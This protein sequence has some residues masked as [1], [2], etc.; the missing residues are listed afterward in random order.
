ML[1][2][3]SCIVPGYIKKRIQIPPTDSTNKSDFSPFQHL[4]ITHINIKK[5]SIIYINIVL[6][7][8]LKPSFQARHDAW[9]NVYHFKFNMY[10]G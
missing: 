3:L 9:K 5:V 10:I 2:V 6:S 8:L 1:F 7:T 4:S